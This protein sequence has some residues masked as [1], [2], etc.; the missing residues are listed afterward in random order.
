MPTQSEALLE[1]YASCPP[2]VKVYETLEVN[3]P[4]FQ[5]PAYIVANVGDDMEF[6]L[7]DPGSP[8]TQTTFVACPV[9]CSY[10]EQ[11]E[12][13]VASVQVK[14]DNVNRELVPKI[15]AA[16]SIRAYIVVTYREYIGSDTSEPAY[17]P[18]SFTLTNVQMVGASL[19]GTAIVKNLQN[20]QF[21]RKDKYYSYL[22]FRSLL[23]G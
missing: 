6:T 9:N 19:V 11:R 3:H 18:I 15:E 12:G 16:L 20:K 17:G 10:P 4:S 1:A 13:Q 21:P 7:E 8:A 22:Q 23:P 5:S 2:D 14:I